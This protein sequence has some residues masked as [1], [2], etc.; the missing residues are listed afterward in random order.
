[1]AGREMKRFARRAGLLPFHLFS[2]Q[3]QFT[4]TRS[5]FHY[6]YATLRLSPE[7]R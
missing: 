6:R 7:V 1:M 2:S 5:P 4:T 3:F